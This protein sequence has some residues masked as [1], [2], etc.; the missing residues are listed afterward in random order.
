MKQ[1]V[2]LL[3]LIT[4]SGILGAQTL[5]GPLV[6]EVSISSVPTDEASAEIR[7][8][9]LLSITLTG[10]VELIDALEIEFQPTGSGPR[11]DGSLVLRVLDAIT[12]T[13]ERSVHEFTGRELLSDPIAGAG[14]R[15]V[16]IP[17]SESASL[18][19]GA[20]TV[21]TPVRIG[22]GRPV[23][24]AVQPVMK[25]LPASELDARYRITA[26]PIVANRGIA[27]ID[28]RDE[29]GTLV[30]PAEARIAGVAVYLDGTQITPSEPVR[31]APGLHTVA[32]ASGRHQDQERTF[33]IERGTRTIVDV[34]LIIAQATI[35]YEAPR[36]SLVYID[37]QRMP[38]ERGGFTLA[39]GEHTMTVAIGDYSVSR[40]FVVEGDKEYSVSISLDIQINETK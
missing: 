40:R 34:P 25:G 12:T 13:A 9:E 1:W 37:G 10:E 21:V 29:Q 22:S 23:V 18:V 31:L 24:V 11:F 30:S 26:R 27:Q 3:L 7:P 14:R 36:G 35:R 15:F 39:P 33:G 38:T 20:G 32:L 19:A 16:R 5:R 17:L 2:V 4:A 8:D 6:A 28:V